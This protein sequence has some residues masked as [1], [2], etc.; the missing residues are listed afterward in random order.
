MVLMQAAPD[1]L[2]ALDII[3]KLDEN[4]VYMD[5]PWQEALKL[6]RAAIAKATGEDK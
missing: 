1:L 2:N 5:E 3:V 4:K 6:A